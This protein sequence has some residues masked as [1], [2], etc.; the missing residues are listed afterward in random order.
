MKI[1]D[2]GF[3]I[4]GGPV[5]AVVFIGL[6]LAFDLVALGFWLLSLAYKNGLFHA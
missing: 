5:L 4:S 1:S 6:A 2:D 3:S